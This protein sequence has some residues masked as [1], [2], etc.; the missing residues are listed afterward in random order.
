[1]VRLTS[2]LKMPSSLVGRLTP[3]SNATDGIG[4]GTGF[5]KGVGQSIARSFIGTGQFLHS[6]ALEPKKENETSV[7]YY[8]RI[9]SKGFRPT[10]DWE[11]NLLGTDQPVSF[12][13]IGDEMLAIG[14]EGFKNK[15]GNFAIPVG[16]LIAGL[17][18]TPIGFGKKEAVKIAAKAISKT[19]DVLRIAK[20]LKPLIKGG[21]DEIKFIAKSLKNVNTEK[22]VLAVL[23]GAGVKKTAVKQAPKVVSK[24]IEPKALPKRIIPPT[25]PKA[26]SIA[27]DAVSELNNALKTAKPLRGELQKTFTAERARRMAQVDSFIKNQ[28][29]NFSGEESYAKILSKM[30]GELAPDS[31]TVFAPIKKK[32][33]KEQVSDLFKTALKH[34]YLTNFEKVSTSDGL[35]RLLEG[36]LPQ[37]KQLVL[38]EEVYGSDLIKN[39]LSMRARG[40][41]FKDVFIETMNIPRAALATADMSAFL[42][43]GVIEI[44]AH[45]IVSLKAMYKSLDFVFHPSSF[46][47][48]F[49][50]LI[51]DPAY[52][53]MRNS[54]LAMT[55]PR[56]LAGGLA[57][58]E[59]AF[60]SRYL[61]K[62]PILG[63]IVSASER[64]YTGFLTKLRV[65][66]FKQW[67]DELLSKGLSPVKDAHIF[68]STANIINTF[69]GRGGL[70]AL[71]DIAP[72]LSVAFFSPRLVAARFN[73]MN[74]VWYATLPPELR[75]KAIGDFAKFVGVGLSTIGLVK[76]YK[77]ANN[78][79]DSK[80]SLEADPRSSD[81][82]KIR[83]GNTR[84]DIWGG[85]QQ[86]AR[87][88]AQIT[89][90][91]R[92]STKT[93][94]I[95]SL[96]KDE[97]PFTTKKEVLL[98]FIEGKLAPAPALVNELMAGAKTFTGEDMTAETVFKEKFIP[99]YIQDIADA[100]EDGGLGKA[101]GAG[102]GAFFGIG[103]QTWDTSRTSKSKSKSSTGG[104]MKMP[105]KR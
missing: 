1:M 50:G 29:D 26:V 51:K 49:N 70:G 64:S 103:V 65:D 13:S 55:D 15:W 91:E 7:Q 67:S 60:I 62:I 59:E 94:E 17:D 45:P 61:Q 9:A 42:R 99:M 72:E 105:S 43:Q 75:Q 83:V 16:M 95:V 52:K 93:G 58:R 80:L 28:I 2:P 41:K 39:I 24:I 27:T 68:K 44:A 48:Y 38:M 102:S 46:V 22:E 79:P 5:W 81:F 21:D 23:S 74:P 20:A 35:L 90:G 101:V 63:D 19:D 12:K 36:S 33:T 14:G 10:N 86:W 78:I 47:N 96:T 4:E 76:M 6:F 40:A 87:V 88:M 100:Y 34:P 71:D 82:G 89:T 98:R 30:K 104:N 32:L 31:K 56:K 11:K 97:Y 84:F 25:P 73:A 53:L 92:K 85:F 37:P 8:E 77:D 18:V 69:T 54:G 66:L 57:A 3:K